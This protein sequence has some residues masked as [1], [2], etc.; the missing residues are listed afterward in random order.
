MLEVLQ[1]L[2][3]LNWLL[4]LFLVLLPGSIFVT[5]L[6]KINFPTG[7]YNSNILVKA[8][9]YVLIS[10]FFFAIFPLLVKLGARHIID[11][12]FH[13]IG[14]PK[15]IELFPSEGKDWFI[16][17]TEI[18]VPN[19]NIKNVIFFVIIITVIASVTSVFL[20]I[21]IFLL[22]LESSHNSL[23]TY[24]IDPLKIFAPWIESNWASFNEKSVRR[25]VSGSFMPTWPGLIKIPIVLIILVL[26]ILS[27]LLRMI[28]S[29][30]LLVLYLVF[31][32]L[33]LILHLF[34][35]AFYYVTQF[36]HH[37]LYKYYCRGKMGRKHAI[38]EARL[39]DNVLI[40]G[41]V[42]T[43]S[44]KSHSEIDSIIL[45]NVMKYTLQDPEK[46]FNFVRG[47]RNSYI[48][49]NPG[50]LL[51]LPYSNIKDINIWHYDGSLSIDN[52][53]QTQSDIDP[54]LWYLKLNLEMYPFRSQQI[55]AR[56][57]KLRIDQSVGFFFWVG[58]VRIIIGRYRRPWRWFYYSPQ[59]QL[60][61][62][63][64]EKINLFVPLQIKQPQFKE[65]IKDIQEQSG[66]KFS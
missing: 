23:S 46:H 43:F 28:Y 53:V 64:I 12:L 21:A 11:P 32:L 22:D 44:P 9:L 20:S 52:K 18:F 55:I 24:F 25:S 8:F 7:R 17:L 30:L 13:I 42:R 3:D 37:P 40:K 1:K 61:K 15:A 4:H 62:Y 34:S 60:L 50:S 31:N 39:I 5:N 66:I 57:E 58:V 36:F 41:R 14:F 29:L 63:A 56:L 45:D 27:G 65:L 6:S 48:F 35:A 10:L 49:P 54:V 2:T 47:Q 51:S 33:T 16:V 19:A 26:L 38:C 59:K